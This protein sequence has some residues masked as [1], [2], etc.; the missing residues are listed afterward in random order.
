MGLFGRTLWILCQYHMVW[1]KCGTGRVSR[2]MRGLEGDV[3]GPN[4]SFSLVLHHNLKKASSYVLVQDA[5][6]ESTEL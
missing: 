5:L 3:L 2:T 6:R 4:W 1:L